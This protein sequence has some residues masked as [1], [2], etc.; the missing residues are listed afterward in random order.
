MYVFV[1]SHKPNIVELA[2]KE[3]DVYTRRVEA[4][5]YYRDE[6]MESW[7]KGPYRRCGPVTNYADI[8]S[9]VGRAF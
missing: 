3:G 2:F 5:T 8:G 7:T 6:V 1:L 9:L 4:Q